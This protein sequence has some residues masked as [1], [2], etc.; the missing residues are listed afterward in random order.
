MRGNALNTLERQRD[1]T[2]NRAVLAIRQ[3]AQLQQTVG[4]VFALTLAIAQQE[5][6]AARRAGQMTST[7]EQA[8]ARQCDAY[9]RELLDIVAV[10]HNRLYRL[11]VRR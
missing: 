10:T 6:D 2:S 3:G 8:L 5:I 4:S 11:L 1:Q 7:K 9:Q